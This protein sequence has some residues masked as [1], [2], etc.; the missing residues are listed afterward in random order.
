MAIELDP[1]TT[2]QVLANALAI[3]STAFI[4]TSYFLLAGLVVLAVGLLVGYIL[5]KSL[6]RDQDP[7][8]VFRLQSV[9]PVPLLTSILVA[10]FLVIQV[11][12]TAWKVFTSEDPVSLSDVALVNAAAT[13]GAEAACLVIFWLTGTV[14]A[15]VGAASEVAEDGVVRSRSRGKRSDRPSLI[16]GADDFLALR[17]RLLDAVDDLYRKDSEGQ[18]GACAQILDAPNISIRRSP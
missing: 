1:E 11:G 18:L 3:A 16:I 10:F 6:D 7:F 15:F 8:V 2:E 5:V 17:L 14:L 9:K 4:E 13:V 12:G